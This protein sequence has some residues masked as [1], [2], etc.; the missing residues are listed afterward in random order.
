MVVIAL[1]VLLVY[2]VLLIVGGILG[3]VLPEKPSRI[4]LISGSVSGIIAI[5]AFFIGRYDRP[6]AGLAIGL[7]VSAGVGCMM[8][9]RFKETRKLMPGGMVAGM[10]AVVTVIA[11]IALAML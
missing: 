9:L 10:S 8:F 11:A 1:W 3:Y 5:G 4:S 7:V 6:L 2:G